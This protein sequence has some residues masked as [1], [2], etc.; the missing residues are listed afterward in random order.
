MLGRAAA[1]AQAGHGQV[2]GLVGEA[3]VGK[4]RVF[5]EFGRSPAM[6]GWLTLEAGSVSYGKATSYLPLIDLMSRYF[7]IQP[8]DEERRAREKI[9]GK[10]FALGEKKLLAQASL[11]LGA[12]GWG[13]KDQTWTALAPAERQKEL[14]SALKQLLIRESQEQPLCLVFE[15][16]HWTDAETQNFLDGLLDSL[17]AARVLLLVNF[18]PEYDM[19][20]AK[21]SFYS[22]A[23]VDPLPALDARELLDALLGPDAELAAVKDALF[24]VTEGNPLFLEESVRSLGERVLTERRAFRDR[25]VTRRFLPQS[26][27]ALLAARIDRLKPRAKE[28]L[29][30]AAVIGNDIPGAA[31][32]GRGTAGR[33]WRRAYEL[34]VAEFY[35][36]SS[37]RDQYTFKHSMTREVAY[38]SL[39]RERR[40][41]LHAQAAHALLQMERARADEHVERVAQHAELG[42]LWPMAVEYLQRAGKKAFALYANVEAADF[43]ERAVAAL[44]HLP[45]T[46]A[47]LELGVDLRIELRNALLPLAEVDRI[48]AALQGMEPIL[49]T[50][51]D[52][53]RSAR[54]AAFRCNHHFLIGEQRRAIEYGEAGLQLARAA[55]QRA[56]EASCSRVGQSYYTLGSTVAPSLLRRRAAHRRPARRADHDPFG[57]RAHMARDRADGTR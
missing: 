27:E 30:C 55:G 12:L 34:E 18:R 7:D 57:R 46:R 41:A 21:K 51:G 31:R 38:S 42:G 52:K 13:G 37:F 40:R 6:H 26:V 17:P 47:T 45:Q 11:F 24:R 44:R 50:L 25:A 5:W 20:W 39:L 32:S 29:Q 9:S 16:L 14:F 56:I 53:V 2:V 15:D 35:E 54:H 10:L 33:G 22:Q 4:S 23:R 1:L 8:R 48:L 36:S 3:G 28:I 43:F 19:H 49:E